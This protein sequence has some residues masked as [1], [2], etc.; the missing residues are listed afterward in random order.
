M[1]ALTLVA[2]PELADVP[3][4]VRWLERQ[5]PGLTSEH[6]TYYLEHGL[7]QSL[8]PTPW[9]IT[10]WYAWQNPDWRLQYEAPYLH[11][12]DVGRHEGR[13]PSPFIDIHQYR[14]ALGDN[15][16]PGV[17]YDLI[18][19]GHHSPALGVV[20]R[21]ILRRHQATFL[22]G[23]SCVAHRLRP[24]ANPRRA[25]VVLQAGRNALAGDWSRDEGR[26]WDLMVNYYDASGFRPGFGDYACFQKGTKFTA[27]WLLLTRFGHLFRTYDH[28]LFLDDDVNTNVA[29]LNRLFAGCRR[30]ELDLAQMTLTDDS[31][32]NWVELFSRS[33]QA[34]P[35]PVSA[36]EIMMPVLS[37]K[38]L[39]LITPTL[40]ESVSGFGLDLVWGKLV[41]DAGGKIA[42][43]DSIVA[44]HRRPV[45]QGSGAYYSYLRRVGINAKA[46]LWA[47]LCDYGAAHDMVTR[48]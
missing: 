46:E 28:V 2:P 8:D 38:A 45:D 13:D 42:V 25:L 35:R 37:Q 9:F 7:V 1:T 41:A 15:I 18:C 31:S 14:S 10:D 12:L 20:D 33:A 27:M 44:A 4:D 43:L 24:L 29:D 5:V 22:A 36:V 39:R 17:I 30:H 19:K 21:E 16:A 6:Q 34:G 23:I 3:V 32:C 40:G 48:G 11:Y 26:E 47:L